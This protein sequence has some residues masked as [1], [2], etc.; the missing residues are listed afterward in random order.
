[1]FFE[2]RDHFRNGHGVGLTGDSTQ[3]FLELLPIFHEPA[4]ANGEGEKDG[5]PKFAV[6]LKELSGGGIAACYVKLGSAEPDQGAEVGRENGRTSVVAPGFVEVGAAVA[7]VV[8]VESKLD[9]LVRIGIS[10]VFIPVVLIRIGGRCGLKERGSQG[11][12]EKDVVGG[13]LE[14]A[15]F[16]AGVLV[17]IP[18][19]GGG[20]EGGRP[21]VD[22]KLFQVRVKG[23]FFKFF[24]NG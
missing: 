5:S 9:E 14:T 21:V 7:I 20:G 15:V 3:D 18:I 2:K 1:M 22:H 23:D 8:S 10:Q 13:L 16:L 17:R 12:V 19:T 6:L 4:I 24:K 11:K